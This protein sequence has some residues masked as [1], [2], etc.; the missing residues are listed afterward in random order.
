MTKLE[1]ITKTRVMYKFSAEVGI[2]QQRLNKIIKRRS[3]MTPREAERISI[4]LQVSPM[5]VM[6]MAEEVL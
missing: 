3:R 1:A 5:A 4:T 6:A 2:N